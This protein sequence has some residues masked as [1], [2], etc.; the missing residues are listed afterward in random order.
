[1]LSLKGYKILLDVYC[2]YVI[3]RKRYMQLLLNVQKISQ[4]PAYKYVKNGTK[5]EGILNAAVGYRMPS[6]AS[7]M[8][9]RNCLNYLKSRAFLTPR[10]ARC[11]VVLICCLKRRFG[12]CGNTAFDLFAL[13]GVRAA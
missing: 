8:S 10:I 7:R 13:S 9:S 5:F 2:I 11:L 4:H 12:S 3:C 6:E 1:M